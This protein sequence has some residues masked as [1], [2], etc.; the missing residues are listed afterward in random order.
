MEAMVTTITAMETMEVTTSGSQTD[1]QF[2]KRDVYCICNE[3]LGLE[4]RKII[5]YVSIY[6]LMNRLPKTINTQC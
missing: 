1:F 2:M 3:R 5:R 4:K 6:N